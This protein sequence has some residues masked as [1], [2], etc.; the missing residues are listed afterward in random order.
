MNKV[1]KDLIE[2]V[3]LKDRHRINNFDCGD[4]S[5][6][7]WYDKFA[8]ENN[9]ISKSYH[10]FKD[11]LPV[12]FFAIFNTIL[13]REKLSG[14]HSDYGGYPAEVSVICIGQFALTKEFRTRPHDKEGKGL[15]CWEKYSG[16]LMFHALKVCVVAQKMT[17]GRGIII[18]P[19]NDR[20]IEFYEK[21]GF[22]QIR[23]TSKK[24]IMYMPIEIAQAIVRK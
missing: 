20:L 14:F 13:R 19:S 16:Q 4:D 23:Q 11:G 15:P 2:C 1:S 17:G 21:F 9:A 24:R 8:Y 5:I 6:N 7:E 3:P 22:Q 18:H 12:G 10:A